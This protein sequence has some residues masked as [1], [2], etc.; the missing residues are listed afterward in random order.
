MYYTWE[1]KGFPQFCFRLF[2]YASL[3]LSLVN[4]PI[5]YQYRNIF[6]E[7]TNSQRRRATMLYINIIYNIINRTRRLGR[8]KLSRFNKYT[9]IFTYS[10]I[11][12]GFLVVFFGRV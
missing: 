3:T 4:I 9:S 8:N 12:F 1:E 2:L 5:R 6:I 10:M 11:A 7:I